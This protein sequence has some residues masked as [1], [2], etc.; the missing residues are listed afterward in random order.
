MPLPGGGSWQVQ[1]CRGLVLL[2]PFGTT[3][4]GP[5]RSR[6]L[7]TVS[8]SAS[9]WASS[10]LPGA[11]AVNLLAHNSHSQTLSTET[12]LWAVNI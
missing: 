5:W 12:N 10:S 8:L 4:K 3:L 9:S 6:A 7:F 11:L 2:Y 1:G